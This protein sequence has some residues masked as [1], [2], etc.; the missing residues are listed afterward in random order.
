MKIAF[1]SILLPILTVPIIMRYGLS[2]GSTPYWLFALI[3]L[4]YLLFITLDVINLTKSSYEKYKKILFWILLAAILGSVSIS[5][6]VKRS[7]VAP[8]FEVHDIILQQEAAIR[9]L[10]D[11]INP[12][13]TDYFGT[14]LE[15]WHYSDTEVNPALYHF[16]MQPFYLT[17]AIP[18]YG[19]S[20]KTL[21]Y[22]D[23]RIPLFF[24]LSVLLL[25]AYL[26]PKK[27]EDKML[28]TM[29][30]AFNP[31]M[32][33]YTLEGRSDVY[34]YAFLFAGFYFLAK[35]KNIL[36]GI[37][38]AL[39]FA[40]KQSAWPFFPL[41][42]IYLY[43]K[44]KSLIKTF[45]A[46]IPFLITFLVAVGPFLVWN[47]QAFIESTVLYLSGSSPTSYPISGY[48]L[49]MLLYQFGL[50]RDIHNYYPFQIWQVAAGLFLLYFL[51]LL[52]KKN[53][54]VK[55]L[56]LSYGIFLFVFWYFSRYFNNSHL[57]FIT[58]VFLAAYFWPENKLNENDKG[59]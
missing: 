59:K 43:L 25:F 37:L 5:S 41:Y 44:N 13:A 33:D 19:L 38:I 12:Y 31:A 40:V 21:G 22:F 35:Q 49:G 52:L 14:H 34:M 27:L 29:L 36:S 17:S 50:I 32:F 26:I 58:M 16:V 7:Q 18:F 15:A 54:S 9:F 53:T 24:L 47:A 51:F 46:L 30:L 8:V 6:I 56:I 42:I 39:A 23:G 48:G 10:L 2:A 57:G 45:K 4:G 3:F 11:G 20:L 55:L 1:S 28:F